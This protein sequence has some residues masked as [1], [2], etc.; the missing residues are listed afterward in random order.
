MRKYGVENFS[1][2]E[3]LSCDPLLLNDLERHYIRFYGTHAVL[4]HGYNLTEGGD[5]SPGSVPTTEQREKMSIAHKGKTIPKEQRDKI[6]AA[7][8][9][10]VVSKETAARI[11]AAKKGKKNSTEHKSHMA[12]AR[13]GKHHSKETKLRMRTAQTE[14]RRRENVN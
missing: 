3:V 2:T 8:K 13:R 14:R 9:G 1:V 10:R 5:G 7:L 6:S 12:E 11:S 4:G